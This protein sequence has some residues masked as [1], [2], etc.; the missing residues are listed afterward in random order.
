MTR[1]T[2]VWDV[3]V[4]A[5]FMNFWIASD[6]H[7]RAILT[8]IA[9]WIDKNLSEDAD[10]K[11]RPHADSTDRTAVVPLAGRRANVVVTYRVIPDDRLVRVTRRTFR[12]V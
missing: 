9:N 8:E 10:L 1:Y 7:M 11:G 12:R 3:D 4:E 6:S 2:V 5:P